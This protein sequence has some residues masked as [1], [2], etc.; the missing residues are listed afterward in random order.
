MS[1]FPTPA[2]FDYLPT[3]TTTSPMTVT[4]NTVNLAKYA[5]IGG[6]CW[7]AWN[8]T[9]TI[10]GTVSA[11]SLEI[12]LPIPSSLASGAGLAFVANVT[13]GGA[14][15]IGRARFNAAIQSVG[16]FRTNGV[17]DVAWVAGAGGNLNGQGIY[18]L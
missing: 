1:I 13:N 5:V 14:T 4:L 9:V 10:S 18:I 8:L 3:V 15:N 17:N 7:L 11:A 6:L 12:S 16:I 2:V